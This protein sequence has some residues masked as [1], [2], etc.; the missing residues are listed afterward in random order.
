[1]ARLGSNFCK[2]QASLHTSGTISGRS[3]AGIRVPA[4]LTAGFSKVKKIPFLYL[5]IYT[6]ILFILSGQCQLAKCAPGP[7]RLGPS[8]SAYGDVGKAPIRSG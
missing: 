2:H 5:F 7:R 4:A 6:S 1:M 8:F 3:T